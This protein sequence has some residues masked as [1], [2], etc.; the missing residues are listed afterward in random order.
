MKKENSK[1]IGLVLLCTMIISVPLITGCGC[2]KKDKKVET[3]KVTTNNNEQVIKDQEVGVFKL[4]NTSL[5]YKDGTSTLLTTVTN[6]SKETQY[7]KS[8]NILVKDSSGNVMITLLGYIGEEIPTGD[9]REITSSTNLDLSKA[10]SIEY[11]LNK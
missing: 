9:I 10:A 5:V 4:M 11:E 2:S 1:K 3:P 8:F 6:T 7:I